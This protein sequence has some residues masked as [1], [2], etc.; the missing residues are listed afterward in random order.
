LECCLFVLQNVIE[1][2]GAPQDSGVP[3][4][5]I[6]IHTHTVTPYKLRDQFYLV[7]F[8]GSNGTEKYA[9]AWVQFTELPSS[10]ILLLDFKVR[11]QITM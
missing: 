1:R 10:C 6:D 3:Q 7:D 2:V 8:P 9:D 4:V 11:S 5:G